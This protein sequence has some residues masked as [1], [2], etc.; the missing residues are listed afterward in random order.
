MYTVNIG[1][2][3]VLNVKR[4]MLRGKGNG[5]K[6]RIEIEE[7]LAEEEVIIRCGQLNDSVVS[8][9]NY[10]SGQGNGKRCLSLQNAETEFF[11]PMDEVYFF[12]TE[13]REVL[14]HTADKIFT[15]SHKLYELEEIL[16]GNFMRISFPPILRGPKTAPAMRYVCISIFPIFLPI[17]MQTASISV[18]TGR[19]KVFF[20][21][22]NIFPVL[23]N[24]YASFFL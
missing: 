4:N 5:M 1:F 11:V 21:T 2:E 23:W 17:L 15:C 14:A 22:Q 7:G 10:I 8:L 19:G 24:I 3:K 9:Q 12:E 20:P 6:V 16:P 18:N 13:G